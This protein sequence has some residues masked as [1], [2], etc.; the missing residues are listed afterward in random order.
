METAPK[1]T[2]KH[3]PKQPIV[4]VNDIKQVSPDRNRKDVGMLKAAIERA[5]SQLSPNR[6]KLYDLYQD[7]TTIDGHLSGILEKRTAA[8]VNKNLFFVD[9]ECKKIDALDALI[10]SERFY[11]LLC[12][13]MESRYWG[14]SGVEFIVGNK[15]D[16]VEIPR[17]HIRAEWGEI[18]K[19]QYDLRGTPT[20]TLPWVWTIGKRRDLG[21]LLK[22][23][24]YALYKRSCF[25]DFAQY[26]EIFG[27]PVRIV[28]YDAYDTR[29]KDELRKILDSSG[30]SL[31]M[32]IPKQAQFE[33]LDGKT[34]NGS[35]E[36]Q[37]RLIAACNA[38]M[39]IAVLGNTETTL[40]SSSSGYAQS[41]EHGK[42]QLEITKN[43]LKFLL[44]T[45]NSEKFLRVL[46]AYGYPVEGGHFEVEQ[47]IDL[48]ELSQRINIDLQVA[49]R[50][51]VSDDYWYN[52]YGIPKPDNYNAL[53]AEQQAQRE[54]MRRALEGNDNDHKAKKKQPEKKKLFDAL[55][56]FFV[57]AASKANQ[58]PKRLSS[59][60]SSFS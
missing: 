57:V 14:V 51:P 2:K 40:S 18:V 46:Q 19:S 42:Q 47:E 10:D 4:V 49:A 13:I 1:P 54:A 30:S 12:L 45:L 56:D 27:Q 28:Y 21:L 32:M 60:F 6:V 26:V 31:A 39:S 50:V 24:M 16:F 17:K 5:E 11:N 15:F 38:E 43:D 9:K 8:V 52:T 55:A 59:I 53:K 34:S 3:T 44:H 48:T 23:S 22:C 25:G 37:E 41:K 7:I 58:K 33:M 35:G 20:D 36:L 29:T